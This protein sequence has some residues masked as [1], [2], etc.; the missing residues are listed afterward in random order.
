MELPQTAPGVGADGPDP[1]PDELRQI[2][3]FD[4]ALD[5]VGFSQATRGMLVAALGGETIRL[6]DIVYGPV[7][8]WNTITAG[9]RSPGGWAMPGGIRPPIELGQFVSVR[10]MP[11]RVPPPHRV[12]GQPLRL[13]EPAFLRCL[14][15]RL[16][17]QR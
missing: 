17:L 15:S 13:L 16:P 9:L 11:P 6:R 2:T 14:A 12:G 7:A 3:T 10:W 1:T 5:W 4:H 8:T